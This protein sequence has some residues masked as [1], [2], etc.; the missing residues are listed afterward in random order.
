M[1]KTANKEPDHTSPK[2]KGEVEANKK[3]PQSCL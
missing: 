1:N 3:G 2:G